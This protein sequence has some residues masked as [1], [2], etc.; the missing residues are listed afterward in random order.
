MHALL[1]R[2]AAA[3]ALAGGLALPPALG[4]P[5][6]GLRTDVAAPPSAVTRI[7]NYRHPYS[8]IDR[9]NDAGNP[10][11][12]EMVEQLNQQQ[13]N[14]LHGGGGAPPYPPPRGFHR[15]PRSNAPGY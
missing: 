6:T 9:R 10:T 4:S 3:L 13:L 5:A 14:Q 12:D 2:A 7:A 11:G 15:P 8:N 1:A